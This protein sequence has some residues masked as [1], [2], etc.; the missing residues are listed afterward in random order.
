VSANADGMTTAVMDG[1]S[2]ELRFRRRIRPAAALRELWGARSLVSALAERELRVRYK[3]AALGI[4]WVFITPVVLLLVFTIFFHRVA[5]VDTGGIPYSLFV[6]VGLLPWTF[7]ST[8]ISQGGQALL[9]N[10]S[11]LNKV[12][13]PREV[14]PVASVLVAG[15]DMAISAV[16]LVGLVLLHGAVPG[17]SALWA[18]LLLF[19]QVCFTLGVALS[20]SAVVVYLRDLR[21]VLPMAL[22]FG[23]FAT[24][25]GYGISA[26]PAGLQ[27]LYVVVNPLAAVI[28]GY[29]RTLFLGLPPDWSLTAPALCASVL[30]LGG[31]YWLFKRLETGFADVT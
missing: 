31:G 22:Q 7:F 4:A 18:P 9:Q 11:L 14:F 3:Q 26:V 1:P 13:C 21:H 6:Y 12:Y 23:L 10:V 30:T 2:S 29:R 16:L 25:V 15:V 8:S 20:V 27:K 17:R 19:V 24:P 5:K 28:E